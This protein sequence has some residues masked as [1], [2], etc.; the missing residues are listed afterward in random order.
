MTDT[1]TDYYKC[2]ECAEF[3]NGDDIDAR[4]TRFDGEDVHEECCTEC[5]P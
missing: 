1:R 5:A 4:H 3:I 2:A